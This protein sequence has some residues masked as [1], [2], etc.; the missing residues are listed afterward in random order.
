[1]TRYTLPDGFT[2]EARGEADSA[3]NGFPVPILEAAAY[4]DLR[5]HLW[6]YDLDASDPYTAEYV[7][8]GKVTPGWYCDGLQ[9]QIVEEDY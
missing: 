2:V 3:W 1:M 5:F 6:H 9:W 8:D 7:N 4:N